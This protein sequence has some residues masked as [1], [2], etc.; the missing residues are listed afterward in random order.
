MRYGCLFFILLAQ[1]AY[2]FS[3]QDLWMTA[4]QQAQQL[5]QQGKFRQ[6]EKRFRQSD[7][8]AVA[9]YRS[10]QYE[11]SAT[12]FSSL[13]SG[14]GDYNQGNALARAGHYQDAIKAYDKALHVNPSDKDAQ[15]NRKLVADL[16]KKEQNNKNKSDKMND[17][18]DKNN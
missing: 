11:K 16:L 5:M 1:N 10:G 13:N 4:D 17:K 14:Q 12:L 2:S 7:W 8:Q 3:W 6:A 9:A 18:N 15:Y